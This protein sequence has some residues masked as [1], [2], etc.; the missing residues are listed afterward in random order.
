MYPQCTGSMKEELFKFEV[1]CTKMHKTYGALKEIDALYAELEKI[2]ETYNVSIYT[3][4]ATL[5][6]ID[7]RRHPPETKYWTN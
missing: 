1:N 7:F 4:T 2:A 6:S 3:I 5:Y